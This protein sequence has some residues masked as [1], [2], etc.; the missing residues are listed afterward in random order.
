MG[1][2]VSVT[3]QVEEP[4]RDGTESKDLPA[5]RV[6]V[7]LDRRLGQRTQFVVLRPTDTHSPAA[8]QFGGCCI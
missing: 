8:V 3:V 6:M 5:G 1:I 7:S 4:R 2:S